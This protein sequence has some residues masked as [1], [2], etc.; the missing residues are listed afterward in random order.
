MEGGSSRRS[1]REGEGGS[2]WPRT[3]C[4]CRIHFLAFVFLVCVCVRVSVTPFL[5]MVAP[6]YSILLGSKPGI[7]GEEEENDE[8]E[9]MRSKGWMGGEKREEKEKQEEQP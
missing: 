6:Q 5:C 8:I 2:G 1:R 4:C 3:F 9:R 7:I